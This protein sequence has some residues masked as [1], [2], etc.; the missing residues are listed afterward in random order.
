VK[1]IVLY[2]VCAG[3][4]IDLEES[5]ARSRITIAAGIK[6]VEGKVALSP[7]VRI[8][9][10]IEATEAEKNCEIVIPVF[11]P[12]YRYAARQDAL[13]HGFSRAGVI[14][15]STSVVGTSVAI[16]RGVYVNAGCT[17]GGGVVIGDFVIVNRSASVGHDTHI[18]EYASIGPAAVL[19]G[20]VNIRRG[21]FVG[22][23]A[24]VLPDI[25]VGEN[26]IVG[27]G[28]VVTR[29][30]PSGAVVV[31]NPARIVKMRRPDECLHF[32]MSQR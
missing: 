9:T 15:D 32:G 23:G 31:G 11:T 13:D 7:R 24:V 20:R 22:A 21:V 27:A 16:G 2:G 4:T 8:L 5:C 30:V 1:Q 12:L 14:I 17:I 18:E 10:P 19:A 26:S 29:P 28:A 25:E 3:L 6:N